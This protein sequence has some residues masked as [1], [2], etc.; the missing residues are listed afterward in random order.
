MLVKR[1]KIPK[2][3]L[4]YNEKYFCDNFLRIKVIYAMV[5]RRTPSK[6]LNV[7]I[8]EVYGQHDLFP[9][10]AFNHFWPSYISIDLVKTLEFH[11]ESYSYK[12]LITYSY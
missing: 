6:Y 11:T 10:I 9:F 7:Q 4:I 5:P 3:T 12:I 8:T 1:S 2:Y